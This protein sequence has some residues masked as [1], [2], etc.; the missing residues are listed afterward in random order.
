MLLELRRQSVY[1]QKKLQ[2]VGGEDDAN[3]DDVTAITDNDDETTLR[4]N[5]FF[6]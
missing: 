4:G 2:D 3:E 5:N 6:D 1:E